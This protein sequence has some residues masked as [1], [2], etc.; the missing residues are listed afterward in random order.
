MNSFWITLMFNTFIQQN[1]LLW[2]RN[3]F[4]QAE[5]GS[6]QK[7]KVNAVNE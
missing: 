1:N 2:I 3:T 5:I 7:R 4:G 6:K